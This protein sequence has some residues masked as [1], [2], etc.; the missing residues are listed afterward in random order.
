MPRAAVAVYE[1]PR[2]RRPV[3]TELRVVGVDEPMIVDAVCADVEAADAA[4]EPGALRVDISLA[5]GEEAMKL[6]RLSAGRGGDAE[7]KNGERF[8]HD[9]N[10]SGLTRAEIAPKSNFALAI[11]DGNQ[12]FR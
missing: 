6:K 1:K 8:A 7:Q 12:K 3:E 10:H 4:L 2:H 5:R 11:V 9:A